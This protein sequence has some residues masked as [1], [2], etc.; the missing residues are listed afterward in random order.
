MAVKD[1]LTK[2]PFYRLRNN[3]REAQ[4]Y[5]KPML[6]DNM[7]YHE[8]RLIGS[9]MTQADYLEEYYP[10]S[11]RVMSDFYFP[12]FYNYTERV[13]EDGKTE[14]EW[15]REETFRIG[16]TI[17]CVTT[18][19]QLV[20]LCGNDIHFEITDENIDQRTEDLF[21][22]Y[23]KGWLR[24]DME[25]VFYQLAE[26]VKMTADGAICF[27]FDNQRMGARVFSFLNG[28]TL[29]PHYDPISGR[30]ER[31]A[32]KFSSYDEKGDEVISWVEVWDDT[33]LTRYR[34]SKT[35]IVGIVNGIK[36]YFGMDGYEVVYRRE[37]GFSR[38]PI[39]Y[40]RD[41]HNGP[42][43]N[44]VQCLIDDYEVALSYF[45]KNNAGAAL[46]S[47]KLKGDNIDIQ[48]DPLGRIR[49]FTMGKDDDV[50]LIQPSG[51]S[52]NYTQYIKYL[53]DEIFQGGFI[54]K[55]P[56]LKSGDT[57]TGT[58]KLYYAPSL[59]KAELECKDYK[60]VIT[61]MQSLF[62]EA[63]GTQEGMRTEFMNLDDHI[64]GW[65]IPF[66][67]ENVSSTIADLVAAKNSGI[68]SVETASEHCL[69]ANNG[70]YKRITAEAKREQEADRLFQLKSA[71]RTAS[72][73]VQ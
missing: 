26:S 15:N 58:M 11:H 29:F 73:E 66:V 51:L 53:L 56:E 34:Q 70:E 8:R 30:M 67:H 1:L 41:K 62:C 16:A 17:Q 13:G 64:Y 36:D 2:K 61:D 20:H 50:S 24:Q 49:A 35:G 19:Q 60:A 59:D 46:P 3:G 48:G 45:A 32:R 28:D 52:E 65:A 44:N 43:W 72:N 54:V 10:F 42:C 23:K 21:K 18:V 27:F 12:E 47:Y 6:V 69:Y 40:M 57:P 71:R 38:C 22:A 37:H 9:Q 63:Y 39:V 14:I 7:K 5:N 4:T 55:Q 25:V 33:Y 31:F 68:L